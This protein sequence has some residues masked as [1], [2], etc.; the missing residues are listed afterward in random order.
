MRIRLKTMGGFVLLLLISISFVSCGVKSSTETNNIK[1]T[2]EQEML[3]STT[4]VGDYEMRYLNGKF[5]TVG[6]SYLVYNILVNETE[7][8]APFIGNI[9]QFRW[10]QPWFDEDT[11]DGCLQIGGPM[12]L[13]DCVIRAPTLS[14]G[15]AGDAM[16]A[17]GKPSEVWACHL[18]KRNTN[19]IALPDMTCPEFPTRETEIEISITDGQVRQ[20]VFGWDEAWTATELAEV[21]CETATECEF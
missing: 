4:L 14:D 13:S 2:V 6:T 7:Q 9:E 17:E 16:W 10:F 8:E 18:E 1:P 5:F 19:T 3:T 12:V 20:L 11:F 15:L 21:V